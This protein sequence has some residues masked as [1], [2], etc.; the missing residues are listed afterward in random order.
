MS[1]TIN[2]GQHLLKMDRLFQPFLWQLPASESL[3]CDFT[4]LYTST[5]DSDLDSIE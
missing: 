3:P 4:Q 2:T 5:A 1:P